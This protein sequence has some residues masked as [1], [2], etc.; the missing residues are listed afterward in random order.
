VLKDGSRFLRTKLE[1]EHAVREEFPEAT[2]I[3]P[4]DIWGQEDRF[5]RVYAGIMR[6]HFRY[7]ICVEINF[8][9]VNYNC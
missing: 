7:V 2:I 8:P 5:L 4:S 1:G 9:A 6:H 3:R